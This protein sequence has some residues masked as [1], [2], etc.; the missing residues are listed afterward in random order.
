MPYRML[1]NPF[2]TASSAV[3][4]INFANGADTDED[5]LTVPA[6][7]QAGDL[8]VFFDS[9]AHDT[10]I[11]TAVTPTGFTN[12]VNTSLDPGR[13]YRSMISY[14]VLNGS[15][16][17]ITG[18]AAQAGSNGVSLKTIL[19]FRKANGIVSVVSSTFNGEMTAGNPALQTVSAS[20]Q[21]APLIV[22]GLCG[23]ATGSTPT[24]FTTA[25]P[26]FDDESFTHGAFNLQRRIGYKIYNASPENHSIDCGDNGSLNMLQSGYLRLT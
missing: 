4:F 14:K 2:I 12:V 13:G 7:A 8:A 26:A 11:P 23:H 24:A 17:T 22:F 21:T 16:V 5:S 9:A 10:T 3:T 6:A 19:I 20:G 18:M 1:V 15:E 25:S